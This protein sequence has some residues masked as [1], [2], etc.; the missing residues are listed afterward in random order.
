MVKNYHNSKAGFMIKKVAKKNDELG[1][2]N[3][4]KNVKNK[5]QNNG[6]PSIRS[7]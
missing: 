5:I 1:S 6:L 2:I 7:E 4:S 3:I